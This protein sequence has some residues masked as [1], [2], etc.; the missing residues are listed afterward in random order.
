MLQRFVFIGLLQVVILFGFGAP[1]ASAQDCSD[2]LAVVGGDWSALEQLDFNGN[3]FTTF[4]LV[5]I[6]RLQLLSGLNVLTLNNLTGLAVNQVDVTGDGVYDS[7]D[8]AII[9]K[10]VF[11]LSNTGLTSLDVDAFIDCARLYILGVCG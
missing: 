2:C 6:R 1:T 10:L 7:N 8:F 4:D 9:Q 3:G 5:V 11:F